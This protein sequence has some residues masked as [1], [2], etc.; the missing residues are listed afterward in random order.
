M[1]YRLVLEERLSTRGLAGRLQ[2]WGILTPKGAKQWSP[3]TIARILANPVYKGAFY[4]QRT[5]AILPSRRLTNDP[6][7][8]AAKTGSRPRP[9]EE[10]I[11]IPVPTIVDEAIW[12]AVQEQLRQNRLNSSRNNKKHAYLLRGLIRC[13]RCGGK[14]TGYSRDNFRGY[15]CQRAHWK[16]SSTGQRCPPGGFLAQPAEDAVWNAVTEALRQPQVL[17]E[18]FEKRVAQATSPDSVKADRRQLAA[19]LKKLI[20]QEDRVRQA[21]IHEAMD[22]DSYKLEMERLRNQKKELDRRK[23]ELEKRQQLE[24]HSRDALAHLERFSRQ[25]TQGLDAMTFEERQTL[26]QLLVERV[27]VEDGRVAIE[28]VIPS[29]HDGNMRNPRRE[30]VEPRLAG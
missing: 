23:E 14:Y 28:T 1:M 6:Y 29:G 16:S 30:P 12:N 15:R 27:T 25:V 2:D 7:K 13:P 26:L 5:E 24:Q 19:A 18:A 10:W 9:E 22:L 17:A 4:Y 8:Q 11:D 20:T 3:T 21:Y